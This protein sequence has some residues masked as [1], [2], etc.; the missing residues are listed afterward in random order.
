MQSFAKSGLKLLLYSCEILSTNQFL[1][2]LKSN[3][4]K[5]N[6]QIPHGKKHDLNRGTN[7]DTVLQ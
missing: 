2:K 7:T 4:H 6:M 5:E 3:E 1:R